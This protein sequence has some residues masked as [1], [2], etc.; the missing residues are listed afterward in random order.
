MSRWCLG[1]KLVLFGCIRVC[2]EAVFSPRACSR[3]TTRW[4]V[5][6]WACSI[7]L[8]LVWKRTQRRRRSSTRS[9]A[10]SVLDSTAA[11]GSQNYI[12]TDLALPRTAFGRRNCFKQRVMPCQERVLTH[13][14]AWR[15]H[16]C[17]DVASSAIRYAPFSSIERHVWLVA[18]TVATTTPG[19]CAMMKGLVL[20]VT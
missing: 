4:G 9:L 3:L 7:S 8:V 15:I 14:S 10:A 16:F 2:D 18:L 13:V 17:E 5:R 20:P 1:I 19:I 11:H 12:K 6:T